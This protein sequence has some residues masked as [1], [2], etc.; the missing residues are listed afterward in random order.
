MGRLV[1]DAPNF[2]LGHVD[3]RRHVLRLGRRNHVTPVHLF[4]GAT[5][6]GEVAADTGTHERGFNVCAQFPSDSERIFISPSG[7]LR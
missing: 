7:F 2:V 3:G 5:A 1:V 4:D 6:F